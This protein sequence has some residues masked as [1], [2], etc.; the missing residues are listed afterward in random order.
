MVHVP[1][2]ATA[3][4]NVPALVLV[5]PV[6]LHVP[7]GWAAVR[8]NAGELEHNGPAGLMVAS[9]TAAPLPTVA[10]FPPEQLLLWSVTETV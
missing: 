8:F 9:A 3:G 5:I 10:L 1:G 2:P 4:L 6:P 7:P